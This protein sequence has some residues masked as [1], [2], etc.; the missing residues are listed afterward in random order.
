MCV[1]VLCVHVRA[2]HVRIM[3]MCIVCV[4]AYA[5]V[6]FVYHE[7]HECRFL[8]FF[9]RYRRRRVYVD[10]ICV[11]VCVCTHATRMNSLS[12][13]CMCA[14][15]LYAHIHTYMRAT[16]HAPTI[17]TSIHPYVNTHT[18]RRHPSTSSSQQ[19]SGQRPIRKRN[20]STPTSTSCN[21]R[22]HTRN[23]KH[24]HNQ[25]R[26]NHDKRGPECRRA[27]RSANGI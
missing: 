16:M 18:H 19:Q 24:D 4:Y 3:F 11:C 9:K 27:T 20:G 17:H 6:C 21:N 25:K 7:D 1:C 2:H 22:I 26:P 14:I 12:L 8:V 23:V 10:V 5:Y 13:V 15:Y